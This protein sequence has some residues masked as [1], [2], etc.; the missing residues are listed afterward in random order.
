M[1]MTCPKCGSEKEQGNHCAVCG[2]ALGQETAPDTA[3]E[4]APAAGRRRGRP[5]SGPALILAL[6]LAAGIVF[7]LQDKK[8][9]EVRHT[10]NGKVPWVMDYEQGLSLARETGRPVM[11]FFTASW[12]GYCTQMVK[13]AFSEDAVVRAME[14]LV[15]VFVDVDL[16]NDL[17]DGYAIRGVPTLIFLDSEGKRLTELSGARDGKAVIT[18]IRELLP[19]RR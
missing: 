17:M 13:G 2:L 14:G 10:E 1:T 16:R 19:S 3:L 12:C 5:G 8:A 11:V 6:A 4:T 18:V 15:P 9:G 7:W